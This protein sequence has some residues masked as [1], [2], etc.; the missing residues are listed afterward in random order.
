M[1]LALWVGDHD[2]GRN[3]LEARRG[4]GEAESWR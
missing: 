3:R 2:E 1:V 4:S